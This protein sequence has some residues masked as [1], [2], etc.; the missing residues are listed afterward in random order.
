MSCSTSPQTSIIEI[1]I[2]LNMN[3]DFSD[4][5]QLMTKLRCQVQW[6]KIHV[7]CIYKPIFKRSTVSTQL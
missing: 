7:M 6:M 2:L 5:Y 3:E 1:F 4:E